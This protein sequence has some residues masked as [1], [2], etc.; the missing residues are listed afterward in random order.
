MYEGKLKLHIIML[1]LTLKHAS[2][3]VRLWGCCT[4]LER[5]KEIKA[6]SA[7]N[8]YILKKTKLKC[9]YSGLAST[10]NSILQ[11]IPLASMWLPK[12]LIWG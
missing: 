5:I 2:G 12:L 10:L 7:L 1:T 3:S 9:C 8:V 4:V 6:W 11:L